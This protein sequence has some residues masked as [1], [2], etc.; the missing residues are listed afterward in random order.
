MISWI[1]FVNF[2]G[3]DQFRLIGPSNLQGKGRVISL[4]EGNPSELILDFEINRQTVDLFIVGK[5]DIPDVQVTITSLLFNEGAGNR[6][7]VKGVFTNS[8]GV[9]EEFNYLDTNVLAKVSRFSRRVPKLRLS[10]SDEFV[11][12]FPNVPNSVFHLTFKKEPQPDE[13]DFDIG[14]FVMAS[15]GDFDIIEI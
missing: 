15:F 5:V 3:T 4:T 2:Q 9:E 8:S 6:L 13:T 1:E 12:Q 7:E 14:T 10:S 11:N